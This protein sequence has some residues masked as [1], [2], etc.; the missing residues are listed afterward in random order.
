MGTT[1][2][3]PTVREQ[4]DGAADALRVLFIED[5]P[6]DVE[7]CLLE[8]KKAGFT[9]AE[10][11]VRTPEEF[12]QRLGSSSYDV[13]LADYYLPGWTGLDAL[14]NLR[15]EEKD[16]P[17]I[18]VTGRLG[19]ET[20]VECIKQGIANYVLK[21]R[22]VRLPLAVRRALEERA[23]RKERAQAEQSRRT[24]EER[25]RHLFERN[26]AGVC[27]T[28]LEGRILDCNDSCARMLGYDSREELLNHP[29]TDFY[30][31]PAER[32][33]FRARLEWEHVLTN[34][35]VCLRTKEGGPAWALINANLVEG[36]DGVPPCIEAT[37][38]DVTER[39]RA[40]T[41]ILRLNR[42]YAVSSNV[43]QV[44]VR[45]RD[46]DQLF[47]EVC[48]IAVEDGLFR[49]AWFGLLDSVTR[50]IRPVAHSGFEDGYL[51]QIRILATDEPEGRGPTGSALRTGQHFVCNDIENDPCMLPWREEAVRRGYRS[52]GAFPV[53][54]QG[55]L[56]GAFSVYASEPGFFDEENVALLD[57]V[58]ADVSF[59]LES[60]EREAQRMRA[61]EERAQAL[62]REEAAKAQVRAEARFRELLE[63]APDAI[64]EIDRD[65]HILLV[66]AATESLVG[67]SREELIGKP[68]DRLIPER[69]REVYTRLRA[70]CLGQPSSRP[71]GPEELSARRKNG[72]ELFVEM[73]LSRIETEQENRITCI[74][75]DITE[76]KHLEEQLRQSQKME[77]IGRLAGGVA[78]DF[79]NLLTIIGGYSQM[80]VDG[81]K[82]R[83]PARRDLEAILEA[84]GRASALTRQLLAFSRRQIVQPKVLDLNRLV[85]K[86]HRLLRPVI[87]EDIE[88]K[89]VMKK[90]LGRVK[91]DPG[92]LEQ[93]LMNLAVNARDAMPR[94]GELVIET[95]ETEA[96]GE[97]A[98]P[99]LDLRPGPHIVLTIRDTGQGMDTETKSHLFEPFFTTKGRGRG[100]GLGLSTVYGII[101]QSG[102]DIAV[103]SEVGQGTT[104]RIYLPAFEAPPKE[105]ELATTLRRLGEGTETILLVEDEAQL[106]KL[107]CE[108]L[109]KQGYSVL[110]AGGGAEALRHWE[111]HRDLIHLLLTDVVMPQMSGR[112]L[113]EQLQASRPDLKVLYMSGY[114]N[115]VIAR[116]GV[117]D[118]AIAFL[119]KPFTPDS[120]GRK[121]RA[122]LDAPEKVQ[123]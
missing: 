75:R 42:L 1:V 110:A 99:E 16:I 58:A 14:E 31:S 23:L 100:T 115:D 104:F 35:E 12:S 27:R 50:Q 67:Y 116:H 102:G 90:S 78:H 113:A 62:A 64:L 96:G 56:V 44:I 65:D 111:Q 5:D 117:L 121:V 80:L 60:M 97:A 7:L 109:L 93:V 29:V 47:R 81:T 114:T 45:V 71:V 18:L 8:L 6:A 103:D 39:K 55:R 11:V 118:S 89:L 66:N 95:S 79:N 19:D 25:Y 57:N 34:L 84:A 30:F 92:Q 86:M 46:R 22:L 40:E 120:L 87:G 3:I 69:C 26:L 52:S 48:R 122:V 4:T 107:T 82:P 76:R 73:N 70:A 28:T 94:G 106:R 51:D 98:R 21:D 77:A 74:I 101:K 68:V 61:E 85:G 108:I 9:V 41:K 2:R 38:V 63:A 20:A 83:D 49:M 43:S 32:E 54:V 105:T 17:F 13:I 24:S 91:A 119:Q 36:S 15:Q 112:E 72:S 53:Q 88:L 37:L 10:D 123:G 59:A 33:L